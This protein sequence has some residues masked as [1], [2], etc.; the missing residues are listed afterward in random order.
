MDDVPKNGTDDGQH[1][2]ERRGYL[3]IQAGCF[4]QRG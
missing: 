3:Y 2:S 1:L 4:G